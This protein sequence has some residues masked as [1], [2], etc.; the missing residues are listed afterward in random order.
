MKT[1]RPGTSEIFRLIDELSV[2]AEHDDEESRA[3]LRDAGIDPDNFVRRV[4]ANIESRTAPRE[5]KRDVWAVVR[6]FA[7]GA[8]AASAVPGAANIKRC[9]DSMTAPLFFAP[10]PVN[11]LETQPTPFLRNDSIVRAMSVAV[12][13]TFESEM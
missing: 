2:E 12:T 3:A 11:R 5:Q 6:G 8:V 7:F 4:R 10:E 13:R 1:K 9:R